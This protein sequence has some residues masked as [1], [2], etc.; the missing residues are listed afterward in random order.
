MNLKIVR[1][2]HHTN[3]QQPMKELARS[4]ML[5]GKKHQQTYFLTSFLTKH[6]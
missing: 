6:V 3:I 5:K 4:S 2:A 1:I